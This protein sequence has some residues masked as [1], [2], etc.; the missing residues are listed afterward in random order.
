[1]GV[2]NFAEFVCLQSFYRSLAD[3]AKAY[4]QVEQERDTLRTDLERLSREFSFLLLFAEGPFAM[5]DFVGYELYVICCFRREEGA[6][7]DTRDT[8]Y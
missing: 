4:V 3:S 6:G 7:G 8:A 2:G 1:M 5:C